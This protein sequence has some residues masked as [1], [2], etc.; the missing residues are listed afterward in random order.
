M[1]LTDLAGR[2]VFFVKAFLGTFTV[3]LV[4]L[5][6]LLFF[7]AP[8][9]SNVYLLLVLAALALAALLQGYMNL[10]DRI[11]RLEKKLAEREGSQSSPE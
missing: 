10:S 1:F 5:F 2:E 3:C 8:L 11:E 7:G 4:V 6:L 9:L